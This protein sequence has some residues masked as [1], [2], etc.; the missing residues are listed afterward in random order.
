MKFLVWFFRNEPYVT[1]DCDSQIENCI[2]INI[3]TWIIQNI[4][5]NWSLMQ[6]K[7]KASFIFVESARQIWLICKLPINLYSSRQKICR[8]RKR[9]RKK[10]TCFV[11]VFECVSECVRVRALSELKHD[12]HLSKWALLMPCWPKTE[13]KS[14]FSHIK[15]PFQF[16]VWVC[17]LFI[18][19]G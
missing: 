8:N 14:N 6:T 12:S 16:Y 1:W 13:M 2:S 11:F 18:A 3:N 9:K 7:Q 4:I 10:E 19:R 15:E 5:E 17:F